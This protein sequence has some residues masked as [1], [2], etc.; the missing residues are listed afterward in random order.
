MSNRTNLSTSYH[1]TVTAATDN[2]AYLWSGHG[3]ENAPNPTIYLRTDDDLKITNASGGHIMELRYDVDPSAW[4]A[5]ELNGEINIESPNPGGLLAA[6]S[7]TYICQTHPAMTGKVII[8]QPDVDGKSDDGY[9]TGPL[10]ENNGDG[11]RASISVDQIRTKINEIVTKGGIGGGS[12]SVSDVPPDN[13]SEGDLWFDETAA[14][15][16]VWIADPTNSWVQTNGAGS[17]SID[18]SNTAPSSPSDGD[19]WFNTTEGQLYVYVASETAWFQTNGG[20]GTA[21]G[22]SVST[23]DVAPA[24]PA[25]GDLW[26]NTVEAELYVYLD[27]EGAWIQTNGGGGSAGGGLEID[28]GY[29]NTPNVLSVGWHSLASSGL[30]PDTEGLL[31]YYFT[32]LVSQVNSTVSFA[33]AD[34]GSPGDA[35]GTYTVVTF[36]NNHHTAQGSRESG[37]L[38]APIITDRNGDRGYY[39]SHANLDAIRL[40][41]ILRRSG[42]GGPRAYVA[43]NGQGTDLTAGIVNSYNVDSIND[44]GVGI[45]TINLTNTLSNGVVLADGYTIW[46]GPGIAGIPV[47]DGTE[48]IGQ[49]YFNGVKLQV[50]VFGGNVGYTDLT[51][52]SVVVH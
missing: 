16:Y 34:T 52:L 11:S 21:G 15:L 28:W 27:A 29:F 48:V 23:G 20:G 19:L 25:D 43:F 46:G 3:L 1:Y 18:V 17:G 8:S 30:P 14:A 32:K 26:F 31:V 47:M 6:S 39:V 50:Y 42:G 22:A 10:P 33:T 44:D 38:I 2:S 4:T 45:Y 9:G 51:N 7:F 37:Q 13:P 24:T 40:D 49:G 35:N 36:A 41:A 5:V 12:I